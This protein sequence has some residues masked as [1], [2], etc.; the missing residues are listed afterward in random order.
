VSGDLSVTETTFVAFDFETTGLYPSRDRIIEFGAVKFRD[1]A[2]I[3]T[4]DALVNPG[5]PIPVEAGDVSRITDE[6]VQDKPPIGEVL[7]QFVDFVS[8]AV[9]VAH[10]AEFDMGFLR[11]ALQETGLGDIR[12]NLI[13][14]QILAQRA[15]PRQKSYSLQNL[16]QELQLTGGNAHRAL[17][18][19]RMCMRLFHACAEELSFMGEITLE[20]VL[21]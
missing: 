6:M 19:S 10:N 15:F 1:R 7:P 5:I 20:E 4:F 18:D 12:N 2:E 21:T 8:D 14:T 9:L 16:V 13:D 17:D 3:D 11:T